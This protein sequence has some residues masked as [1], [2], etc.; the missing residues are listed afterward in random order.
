MLV[1]PSQ[2]SDKG[3]TAASRSA[4]DRLLVFRPDS[5]QTVL[6]GFVTV[7][8]DVTVGMI[9]LCELPCLY[10]VYTQKFIPL[11]IARRPTIF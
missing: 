8:T 2:T 11:H 6:E 1:K 4:E 7:P 3:V 5:S 10:T 9:W